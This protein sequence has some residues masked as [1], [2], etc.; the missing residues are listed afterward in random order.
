M[1]YLVV[2]MLAG[3]ASYTHPSKSA[4]DLK[5]DQYEC[6][7]DALQAGAGGLLYFA[8]TDACMEAR[9]WSD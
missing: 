6:Q 8:M 9:G 3:C 5:T 4:A 1:R 2:L 7:R